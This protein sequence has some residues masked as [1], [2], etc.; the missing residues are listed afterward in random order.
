MRIPA[1]TVCQYLTEVL[2]MKCRHLR[3]V[4]YILTPV[5]KVMSVELA[6]GMLQGLEKHEHK[7][8][9]FLFTGDE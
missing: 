9:C 3:W 8:Y 1:S 7:N 2:G 5:Q 4:P 6:R